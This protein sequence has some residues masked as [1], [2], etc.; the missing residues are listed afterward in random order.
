[1]LYMYFKLNTE[2]VH[3]EI[4]TDE[5]YVFISGFSGAGKSLFVREVEQLIETGANDE[6][7]C[8]LDFYV[9][10][11]KQN[12]ED[13]MA[14]LGEKPCVLIADEF[15]AN[16]VAL[17]I[18]DKNV[19][20]ICVTRNLPSNVNF[21]YKSLYYAE[22]DEN[23]LTKI[24]RKYNLAE[25]KLLDH[26]DTMLIEDSGAGYN[27]ICDVLQGILVEST[28]GKG[29]ILKAM[30]Q[31]PS[32]DRLLLFVDAGGIGN[33]FD[34]IITNCK[35]REKCGGTVHLILPECF[36][37]VLVHSDLLSNQ[38]IREFM[39][40]YNNKE[41]FYEMEICRLTKGTVL[42]YHHEHQRLSECWINDCRICDR[43]CAFRV[44]K[45][46]VSAV[47]DKGATKGL[48]LFVKEELL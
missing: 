36:E 34:S 48:M 3:A 7:V 29:N 5:K 28:F 11:N 38:E 6:I 26:Y 30:R 37:Q 18:K 31:K 46:K 17:A 14:L 10:S 25:Y 24:G 35:K 2:Y 13:R 1:M 33:H 23:G 16:R 20:C 43:I 19:Y 47:L 22:R 15:Y 39:V 32:S 27:Y 21:S 8:D 40:V 4:E 42:E 9:I 41:N 45:P 12:F 44:D